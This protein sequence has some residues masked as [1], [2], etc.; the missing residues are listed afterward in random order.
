MRLIPVH[1]IQGQKRNR[2]FWIIPFFL[3]C[4]ILLFGQNDDQERQNIIE[5]RIE[6]IAGSLEEDAEVDY[7][8]LLEDL[9]YYYEHPLNI[10]KATESQLMDLYLLSE[11]QIGNLTRHIELY[12]PLRNLHELQS[13]KGFDL[14]T[15]RNIKPFVTVAPDAALAAMTFSN[16]WKEGTHDLFLR[17]KR[18]I[19][20]QRGFNSDLENT[21]FAGTPDYGYIRYR[22]QYRKNLIIGFTAEND[23]G[24]SYQN[25]PDFFSGHVYYSDTR[26]LRK[27]IFG[28]FQGL[29]GQGLT[30]WNG[31]GFGK[32]SFV[33]NLKRNPIGLRPYTSTDENLFMRGA[34]AT[35]GFGNLEATVFASSK[36]IDANTVLAE[37]TIF[38]DDAVQISAFQQSGLH[39]TPGEIADK[40]ALG[41]NIVGGNLKWKKGNL[42][43][44][45]TWVRTHYDK[46]IL[47]QEDLYRQFRF[48]GNTQTAS[49]LDYHW[50]YRNL[51]LFGEVTM[52]LDGTVAMVHGLVASL[53]NRVAFSA[54]YRNLPKDFQPSSVNVFSESSTATNESGLFTGLQAYLGKGWTLNTYAD[55]IEYPWLRFR[56]DAPSRTTD[57]LVQANYKPDKKHEFYFRYRVRNGVINTTSSDEIPVIIDYPVTEVRQNWRLHASYKVHDNVQ[58]RTRLEWTHY[59]RKGFSRKSGYLIYQ[60]L[61]WK[62]LGVPFNIGARYALF[63]APDWDTR[64]YAYETDVLY[65]FS[66]P[67]YYGRGA[68]YYGMIK[69][70]INRK[71]DLWVRY[72]RWIY[73]DRTVI[74]SGLSQIDGNVRSDIHVQLRIRF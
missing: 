70:D 9:T 15:I 40:D 19:E 39:R 20:S 45:A 35:F 27:V 61:I 44:G 26:F 31:L 2:F 34:G 36:K 63:D 55:F 54:M 30:Y 21:N 12:G 23:A 22:Y 56:V 49:G 8:N 37:D 57:Y 3:L 51:S 48:N 66:I 74:S 69:C 43:L 53:S 4:P 33:L 13:V 73:N 47:P 68:R 17:Y 29:F 25:G 18:N 16:I 72:G 38:T 14:A 28:D 1:H 11:I 52:D 32:S 42:Q 10:N 62:K 50:L 59:D 5:Q 67:A 7:T 64:L 58:L 24:E 6:T 65:A 71:T 46:T 60:D 41:E